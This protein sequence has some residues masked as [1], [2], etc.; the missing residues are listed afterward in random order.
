MIK[1]LKKER[2]PFSVEQFFLIESR[3]GQYQFIDRG[4]LVVISCGNYESVVKAIGV[5]LNRYKTY[6]I[7][8]R[9]MACAEFYKMTEQEKEQKR[10][11]CSKKGEHLSYV[12]DELISEYL[13]GAKPLSK[14]TSLR[15]TVNV[16]EE[17]QREEPKRKLPEP[18]PLVEER[19][20]ELNRP[21]RKKRL[22]RSH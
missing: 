1:R 10:I 14:K 22:L 12:L 2:I 15:S 9:K 5:V 16:G 18:K 3:E 6:D 19:P 21:K 20:I 11:E 17:V 7:L 4:T 13:K 8:T